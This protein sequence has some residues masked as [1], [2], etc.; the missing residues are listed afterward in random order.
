VPD[1]LESNQLT[2]IDPIRK[3]ELV[4]V[5]DVRPESL[6]RGRLRTAGEVD[7]GYSGDQALDVHIVDQAAALRA[8]IPFIDAV[9]SDR[10]AVQ[11]YSDISGV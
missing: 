8:R 10:P 6:R 4:S 2:R 9:E 3:K 7:A 5:A 1:G 11:A